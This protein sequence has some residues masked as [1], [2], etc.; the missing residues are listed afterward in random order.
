MPQVA[1]EP[2][3]WAAREAQVNNDLYKMFV[4]Q[5]D[6][7]EMQDDN[8]RFQQGR[9]ATG[10]EEAYKREM[11]GEERTDRRMT[12]QEGMT[13]EGWD[14]QDERAGVR[15]ELKLD[16]DTIKFGNQIVRD[17]VKELRIPEHAARGMVAEAMA[18][19]GD[20]RQ[21]QELNPLVPGSRGGA[22]IMQWTGPRRVALEQF[23]ARNGMD[24]M[25][26]E[27]GRRFL[28]E[29]LRGPEGAKLLPHLMKSKDA[30]EAAQATRGI[31]LRPQSVQEGW[32]DHGRNR[33]VRARLFLPPDEE[34][35][36]VAATAPNNSISAPNAAAS[37]QPQPT[38]APNN[39]PATQRPRVEQT[40]GPDGKPRFTLKT[41]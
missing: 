24:P 10:Y 9:D 33:R 15:E 31:F 18:E 29:E 2:W 4:N 14:R 26:R 32:T 28:I 8:Q 35:Q 34:Q 21:M 27:T 3:Q 7:M 19:S 23:A 16:K 40:I 11:R 17:L 41:S 39:A 13:R 38:A 5:R 22:N 30:W 1:Q 12:R 37:S 25:D 36:Q 20:F 6:R